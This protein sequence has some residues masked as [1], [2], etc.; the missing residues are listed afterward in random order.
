M[1]GNLTF[2]P[3]VFFFYFLF[4][5]FSLP[6]LS[7]P[8]NPQDPKFRFPICL[9]LVEASGILVIDN[10][11]PQFPKLAP[12][13]SLFLISRPSSYVLPT[14]EPNSVSTVSIL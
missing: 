5:L 3:Q 6:R 13:V 4:F 2:L 1:V 10:K 11:F 12:S 7:Y 9:T 14:R 8:G